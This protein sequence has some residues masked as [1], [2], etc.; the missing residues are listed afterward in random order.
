MAR[1]PAQG[2]RSRFDRRPG[3]GGFPEWMGVKKEGDTASLAPNQFRDLINVRLKGNSIA[4][5]GGQSKLNSVALAGGCISGI[6]PAEF[7]PEITPCPGGGAS[8][9]IG[10]DVG[11]RLYFIGPGAPPGVLDGPVQCYDQTNGIRRINL[12]GVSAEL[13]NGTSTIVVFANNGGSNA[14]IFTIPRNSLT[15]TLKVSAG[16]S[17]T[18]RW[19]L[20]IASNDYIFADDAINILKWDGSSSSVS[21]EASV[22]RSCVAAVYGGSAYAHTQGS[23]GVLRKRIA[24]AWGTTFADPQSG[25]VASDIRVLG[26]NLYVSGYAGSPAAGIINKFDGAVQ[27]VAR[28]LAASTLGKHITAMIV[29]DSILY[30]AWRDLSAPTAI[31]IGKF[32]G[33]T[34]TDEWNALPGSSALGVFAFVEYDNRI[35]AAIVS[36]STNTGGLY[37]TADRTLAS[38]F[39]QIIDGCIGSADIAPFD[40]ANPANL[41]AVF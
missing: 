19:A 38:P 3:V 30:Y 24:G 37:V 34:W 32:D 22:A 20:R 40:G 31:H 29:V 28:T 36:S 39:V 16:I 9:D 25:F 2:I 35:Y 4:V 15:P 21:V 18:V 10:T 1:G 13:A 17:G 23:P 8:S 27:T 5:R 14:E 12:P 11:A 6:F 33:T 41:L 7:N 26:A